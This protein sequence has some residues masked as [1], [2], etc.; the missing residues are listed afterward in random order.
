MLKAE[1]RHSW[2]VGHVWEY[3]PPNT[4]YSYEQKYRSDLA[5]VPH[6]SYVGEAEWQASSKNRAADS[7]NVDE[8]ALA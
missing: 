7:Q 1:L 8:A 2:V 3:P 6:Y 4:W 5:S